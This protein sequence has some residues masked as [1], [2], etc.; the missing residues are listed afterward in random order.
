MPGKWLSVFI[1]LFTYI[2]LGLAIV[3]PPSR[4]ALLYDFLKLPRSETPRLAQVTTQEGGDFWRTRLVVRNPSKS[5]DLI[6]HVRLSWGAWDRRRLC[7]SNTIYHYA[8]VDQIK[9]ARQEPAHGAQS[10]N[11]VEGVWVGEISTVD[12]TDGVGSISSA[13][14]LVRGET[15][16]GYSTSI[17]FDVTAPVEAEAFAVLDIDIP[18]NM[19]SADGSN[20]A[21]RIGGF[22][23]RNRLGATVTLAGEGTDVKIGKSV[24]VSCYGP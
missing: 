11:L 3:A 19:H 9:I 12:A 20:I 13:R 15:C 10:P 1:L 14:G 18:A 23:G 16:Y 22:E 17:D 8:L 5:S 2:L 21:T 6:T 7:A 24:D 4:H